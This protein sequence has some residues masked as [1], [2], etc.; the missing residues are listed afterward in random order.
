MTIGG[1]ALVGLADGALA[2]GLAFAFASFLYTPIMPLTETYALRGLT[3][4]GRAYG[5]VRLWGSLAFI[6]G[7]FAAGAVA[8]LIAHRDLI[9]L[10]VGA[11]LLIAVAAVALDPLDAAAASPAAIPAAPPR[12]DM[13]RDPVF[14]FAIGAASLAQASHAVYY[15]FSALAWTQGGLDGTAVAVLWALG[16]IAEIVLF[17]VQGRLPRALTPLR[18]IA[19][20]AAGGAVRWLAMAFDPPAAALPVLQLLHGLSFGAAHLG[21]LGFLVQYAPPGQSATA[22]GYLAIA[23]GLTMAAATG[24]AGWLFASFGSAAYAAM[25]LAAII[26]CAGAG[27]AQRLAA[28][29]PA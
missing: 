28:K 16:V 6:V 1:Y 5:P 12:R 27:I 25:A 7:T 13:L 19:L 15:G 24:L 8:D 26:G 29:T 9:W 17:A 10:I 4:R 2:I 18:M 23:L 20:G 14:L 3:A 21:V 22:Q 11:S